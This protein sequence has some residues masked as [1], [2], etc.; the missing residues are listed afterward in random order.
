M[1]LRSNLSACKLRAVLGSDRRD[2]PVNLDEL[3]KMMLKFS[4]VASEGLGAI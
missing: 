1:L 4:S 3:Q 2:I